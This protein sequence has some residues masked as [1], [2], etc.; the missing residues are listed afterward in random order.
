MPVHWSVS[1]PAREQV[2][3]NQPRNRRNW[4]E[5]AGYGQHWTDCSERYAIMERRFG[6]YWSED[7]DIDHLRTF[8]SACIVRY[9]SQKFL[10]IDAKGDGDALQS[11]I[12]VKYF[13]IYVYRYRFLGYVP[14]SFPI[15]QPDVSIHI[16]QKMQE[17]LVNTY[18][19]S[20][21]LPEW[22]SP[23]TQGLYG[24]KQLRFRSCRCLPERLK[25][26]DIETLWGS[27]ETRSECSSS[28][29]LFLPDV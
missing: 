29:C 21:F 4:T 14:L 10:R 6:T 7:D 25:G 17:G 3:V 19:E 11:L 20:G 28:E 23:R 15:P 2:N 13:R 26:Y 16:E 12:M 1:K 9:F 22:A 24:W 18:K 27:R 5:R 8:Y